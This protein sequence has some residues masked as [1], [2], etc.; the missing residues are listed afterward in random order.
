MMPAALR[1]SIASSRG[2]LLDDAGADQRSDRVG[3]G[4]GPD[5][6]RGS[7]R[8]GSFGFG[9]EGQ[10][11][12]IGFGGLRHFDHLS[13]L[14]HRGDLRPD[15]QPGLLRQEALA[16]QRPTAL[17][18][19]VEEWL[20]PAVLDEQERECRPRHEGRCQCPCVEPDR[21]PTS[22]RRR[23]QRRPKG[24]MLAK[25]AP[26]SS[27][28]PMTIRSTTPSSLFA[29]NNT[30]SSRN[31]P[32]P[33]SRSTSARTR[34]SKSAPGPKLTAITCNGPGIPQPPHRF[35]HIARSGAQ[36]PPRW[37]WGVF[38]AAGASPV[39]S[40]VLWVYPD[41]ATGGSGGRRNGLARGPQSGEFG[42][43]GSTPASV[44]Q[45]RRRHPT[46]RLG[47][48]QSLRMQSVFQDA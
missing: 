23:G 2:G 45:T 9:G 46:R 42:D 34:P 17:S 48:S 27:S 30:S 33:W 13:R 43:T 1:A 32:R 21:T 37:D 5:R 25:S 14:L 24:T 41:L 38:G 29:T 39:T 7:D 6:F 22:R 4:R 16:N 40:P 15:Q 44:A 12:G 11:H 19:R 35:R 26:K 3:R 31:T 28:S 36:H 8:L 20:R 47:A 10:E 18:D